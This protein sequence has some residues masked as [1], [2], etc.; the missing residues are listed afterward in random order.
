LTARKLLHH[1]AYFQ[2]WHTLDIQ[3]DKGWNVWKENNAR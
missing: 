2:S 1:L 3:R